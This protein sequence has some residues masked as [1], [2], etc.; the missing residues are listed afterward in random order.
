MDFRTE[1]IDV[2]RRH[3]ETKIEQHRINAEVIL[4]HVV[5]IGLGEDITNAFDNEIAK[6]SEYENKLLTLKH[7]FK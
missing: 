3:Y 1:I 5:S 7:Y 6:M 4:N 2:T